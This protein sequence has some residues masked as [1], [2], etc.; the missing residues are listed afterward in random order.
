MRYSELKSLL[1]IADRVKQQLRDHFK[2]ENPN[3]T[4]AQ[5]NYYLDRW[6]RF[7]PAFDPQFRDITRLT[8]A[9]IEKLID[10]AQ[11]RSELKGRAQPEQTFDQ[12]DD[13]IYDQNGLTILRGDL[14]EKCI[15]YGQ[16]YS[17]CI[18]RRDAS[19]MFYTYRMRKDEPVFYFVF[20]KNRPQTDVWHAVVI[21]VDKYR[22]YHVATADNPGDQQMDWNIILRYQPRLKGLES[23]FKSQPL[24]AEEKEDWKKFGQEVD[25]ETYEQFNLRDKY[26]YIQFGHDLSREQQSA[27]PQELIGTY[28]KR[29]PLALSKQ[30]VSRLN[31]SD[32]KYV[33]AERIKIV[34]QNPD[35]ISNI[36]EPSEAVQMAAVQA[37][38]RV[39]VYMYNPTESVQKYV[40]EQDIWM[41]PDIKNA[42]PAVQEYAVKQMPYFLTYAKNQQVIDRLL[43]PS[44]LAVIKEDGTQSLRSWFEQLNQEFVPS[45]LY[46]PKFYTALLKKHGQ[47]VLMSVLHNIALHRGDQYKPLLDQ[48]ETR[49]SDYAEQI[50]YVKKRL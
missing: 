34:K 27:T 38:Y 43:L 40:V 15:Q 49:Y 3:L 16:G 46:S 28:A 30:T 17:W 32:L 12:N 20:D 13:L 31:S 8:F 22:N 48:W 36:K 35:L 19:N 11:T 45:A 2:Q 41:F 37:D 6:D 1:E 33:E 10:D 47:A 50:A 7:A 42:S 29:A 4:D 26:K 24:T 18:S 44:T 9:Q 14:R 39:I 23:L 21:Y 5:I 25:D